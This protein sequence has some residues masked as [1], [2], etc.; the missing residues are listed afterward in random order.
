[1]NL[2]LGTVQFGL[3]YGITN[4]N[5]KVNTATA[6]DILDVANQ[7]NI[8]LLDTAAAYGD[9]EAVLGRLCHSRN[10]FAIISKIPSSK[11][12]VMDIKTSVN[13]SLNRLQV[14]KLHAI[15]FHDQHD[16]TNAQSRQNMAI[17]A[18]LKDEQ[19]VAKI[20]ASFYTP[21]ALESAL[22]LHNLDIIQIPAN[23]LDQRFEQSG[24]LDEAKS[25][26]VEIHVRSLFLQ[27]LLLKENARLPLCLQPFKPELASYFNM[28][29]ELNL[30]PLQLA[31]LYLISNK[32]MDY[33]VVGCVNPH[34]LIEITKAYNY[35]QKMLNSQK[36]KEQLDL[37]GLASSSD[38]L[39]NPSL[40]K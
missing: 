33:G 18:Q 29:K 16:I 1:M 13:D 5:G 11:T 20:G 32:S 22:S 14:D 12:H 6:L 23:C 17:L 26:G 39:I 31:L 28:A 8:H 37:S 15:L 9:S 3:D 30:E 10:E 36:F 34:Q 38:Q 2:I 40:W 7:A 27:G 19:K 35:V 21:E 4:D 24:L 25:R